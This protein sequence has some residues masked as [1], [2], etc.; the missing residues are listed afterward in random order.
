MENASFPFTTRP[1]PSDLVV[2]WDQRAREATSST[3][4]RG[5]H[6]ASG[7]TSHVQK[8]ILTKIHHVKKKKKGGGKVAGTH[9]PS[10]TEGFKSPHDFL[11]VIKYISGRGLT[12]KKRMT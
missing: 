2:L 9:K 8:L 1:D 12:G 11:G 5:R 4:S 6:D 3:V 7:L 10:F